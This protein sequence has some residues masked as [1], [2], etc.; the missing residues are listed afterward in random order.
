[1]LE[2][3]G[4]GWGNSQ[5][6]HNTDREENVHLTGDGT[7]EIIAREEEY[8]GNAYTSGRIQSRAL[9]PLLG[10]RFEARIRMP[11]GQGLWPAF[12]LLGDMEEEPWPLCGEIDIMEFRGESPHEYLTTVHGPGYSGGTS[13]GATHTREEDLSTDFHVY[14]VE[15]DPAYI[16]WYLD[17]ERVHEV[18]IGDISDAPWVF[19]GSMHIMLNLAVGGSFLLPPNADTPF[20]SALE[21]DWV[22]YWQRGSGSL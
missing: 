6:E 19:D 18:G 9:F 12:W 1:M 22:Q 7:L 20:P 3:G 16:A 4:H 21:I 15:I 17:D 10:A 2:T 5:L 13:V 14:A 11:A 8:E